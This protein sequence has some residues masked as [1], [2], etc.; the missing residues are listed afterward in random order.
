MPQTISFNELV[1]N[2][3][4]RS[5][6]RERLKSYLQARGKFMNMFVS[7]YRPNPDDLEAIRN[8]ERAAEAL[9]DELRQ[10]RF[11]LLD[12]VLPL[13]REL[14]QGEP[15]RLCEFDIKLKA[16]SDQISAQTMELPLRML[17]P[18]LE[19]LFSA[20]GALEQTLNVLREQLQ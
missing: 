11:F 12:D 8:A 14:F 20:F 7:G 6:E 19:S 10:R 15:E 3:F 2:G 9:C 17:V 4:V 5:D 18:G 1:N 13:V 16:F